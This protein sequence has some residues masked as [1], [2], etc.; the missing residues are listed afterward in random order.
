MKNYPHLNDIFITKRLQEAAENMAEYKLS[1]VVAPMGYGKSTF[2]NWFTG[3]LKKKDPETIVLRQELLG[4]STSD[5]WEG[6]CHTL[7]D[8]EHVEKHLAKLSFPQNNHELRLVAEIIEDTWDVGGKPL[9]FILDNVHFIDRRVL[10]PL[11]LILTE[12]LPKETH[13]I[14]VSRKK[15]M[16]NADVLSLGNRLYQ[17]DT[18]DF[19]LTDEDL[20]TYVEKC[21]LSISDEEC[22][23]L[24]KA[25]EGW[26]SLIYLMIRNYT[27]SGKWNYETVDATN[28]MEQVAYDRLST[29]KKMFLMTNALTDR[30]TEE[31]VSFLFGE[32]DGLDI[33]NSLVEDNSFISYTD[34]GFYRYH[35]ML[36]KCA[37]DHFESLTEAEKNKIYY[38]LGLF[39]QSKGQFLEA[40]KN[41]VK[42]G[43]Y[44]AVLACAELNPRRD[45]DPENR[46]FV[47]NCVKTCPR[48]ILKNHPRAILSFMLTF[49]IATNIPE[50][51][52]LSDLLLE[53]V[54]E[55]DKLSDEEKNNYL[56]ER[57]LLMAFLAY[58]DSTEMN[59]C[60]RKALT[61]LTRTSEI[62]NSRA[63]WTFGCISVLGMYHRK[64]GDLQKEVE[65]VKEGLAAYTQLTDGH[66]S[67]GDAVM[68]GEA[69]YFSGNMMEAELSYHIAAAA[70]KRKGQDSVMF[71]AEFLN[72]RIAIYRGDYEMARS[73]VQKC[74][75]HLKENRIYA[76]SNSYD[77]GQAWILGQFFMPEY[78]P[79]WIMDENAGDYVMY[80]ALPQLLIVRNECL[81]ARKEYAKVAATEYEYVPLMETN[82]VVLCL[83]YEYLQLAVAHNALGHSK[84][85]RGFVMKAMDLAMPDQIMMPFVEV[86]DCICDNIREMGLEGSYRDFSRALLRVSANFR[87]G[88]DTIMKGYNPTEN[89]NLTDRE[90]EIA[91]L[92]GSRLTNKEI[93]EQLHLSDFTVKNH[94]KNIF[95]KVGIKGTDKNKRNLLAEKLGLNK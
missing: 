24:N 21:G 9:Y 30:F 75:N 22:K 77:M 41:F 82:N 68:R 62:I 11:V 49:F 85:A 87:E 25:C 40:E 38:Q 44:E 76:L 71:A 31:Q 43:N 73:I 50:M 3:E 39:Q 64:A 14:L 42:A 61:M 79:E 55:N 10:L 13:I 17:M 65:C 81:I 27:Q 29:K 89:F 48:G 91:K 66:G 80:Q 28:L 34:D 12:R 67:G 78:I 19:K 63:P 36:Q 16:T 51:R 83:I 84:E 7:K 18:A 1:T 33:L 70:A 52:F 59:V 20:K 5:M 60:Q 90:M 56:G 37:L 57:E 35:T 69:A 58:N 15:I 72:L 74:A 26:I 6:L 92:A 47:L 2:I 23:N 32:E 88:K 54:R 46:R 53:T 86:C 93:A 4:E 45:F 95:D 8:Y 94:L